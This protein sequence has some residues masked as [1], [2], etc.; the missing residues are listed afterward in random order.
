[1]LEVARQAHLL[2]G[3]DRVDVGGVRRERQ[4]GAVAARLVDQL[5]DQEVRAIRPFVRKHAL[6][7]VEPFP[8][9]LR[10]VVGNRVHAF[11]QIT[12]RLRASP[13][14]FF[15]GNR[16]VGVAIRTRS[17][18]Q[19][20]RPCHETGREFTTEWNQFPKIE[21]RSIGSFRGPICQRLRVCEYTLLHNRF[22]DSRLMR[23]FDSRRASGNP[24]KG[25]HA[26]VRAVPLNAARRGR[27]RRRVSATR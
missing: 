22:A 17:C 9:F 5:L 21:S 10:V 15:F 8:G 1:M 19:S 24:R 20:A 23:C 27:A 4:V 18:A 6:E 13:G 16:I 2:V 25:T 3:R 7:R 11:L 14:R 12:H 26:S